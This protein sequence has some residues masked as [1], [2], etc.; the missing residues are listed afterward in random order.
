MA[1]NRQAKQ[2]RI[3]AILKLALLV[4]IIVGVPVFLYA[5]Y[6]GEI[7]SEHFA[8]DLISYLESH[9]SESFATVVLLQ[10]IQVVVCILP[11]QP[12]QIA[13]SYMFG[14]GGALLASLLGAIIGATIAFI[15]S[16]VLGRS[17]MHVLFGEEK[18]NYYRE[19]LNSARGILIV[20]LI[21]LIPGIPKDLTAYAAG[22]SEMRFVPFLTA[23]T[24]GRIPA[25]MG[26]I[27][28]GFFFKRK[29][30]TAI[31]ILCVVSLLIVVICFIK[32]KAILKLLDDLSEKEAKLEEDLEAEIEERVA[33]FPHHQ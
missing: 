29:N 22:I 12:I 33:K 3:I 28:V 19:K 14:I 5:R 16:R 2:K 30:Y 25:M 23:A 20:F 8:Q 21:H 32:R 9:R 7:F 15:I 4:L 26:S 27:L 24:V 1:D 31:A 10:A 18:M 11:G 6:G 17:A 13:G